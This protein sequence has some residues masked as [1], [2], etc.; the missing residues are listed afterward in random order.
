V[1]HIEDGAS[2]GVLGGIHGE[3]VGN[4]DLLS[5]VFTADFVVAQA[6]RSA[7]LRRGRALAPAYGADSIGTVLARRIAKSTV[8][9]KV[10]VADEGRA[11]GA[12]V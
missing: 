11:R 9:L 7:L 6:E 2:D 3:L 12:A 4:L 1:G 5:H 8:K 10:G